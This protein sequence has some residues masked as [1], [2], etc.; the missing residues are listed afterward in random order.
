MSLFKLAST[1][2]PTGDQPEAI[3]ALTNS[4]AKSTKHQI[5]MGVTGSGKTFTM[6]NIIAAAE[7]PTLIIAPNKTLA[8]QLF[9]EMKDLFPENAVGF[10]IS[11]YDYYQPEAYIP[12]TDTYIAKDSS[13]NEDIDKM[14]HEATRFLFERRDTIIVASVSCI[15][16]LGSPETYAKQVVTV[17]KGDYIERNAFLRKLVDIQY[18]RNDISFERGC[19]RVRGDIVDILP[20]H[21]TDTGIRVEFFGD[22]IENIL[23]IDSLTGKAKESLTSLSIYPNSHYITDRNDIRNIVKDIL[24]DLGIRLRE[25]KAQDKLVEFQR[26]EQRTMHDV[27]LLEQLGFCPGI[28]NYSRYL[29]G[30]KPGEPP[31]TLLDYFPPGFI[32]IIDESHITVPQVRGMYRGDISRKQTLVDFG[33]RLPAAIDN[34]PLNFE[35]FLRKTG[36]LIYVSATPGKYEMESTD[37]K[38]FEQII[39]PTGIIDPQIE[40]RPAKN[41]VDDLLGELRKVIS[42][43]GRALVTTLTKKMSEDLTNYYQELGLKVRYLHSGIDSIER[44][45]LLRDLRKGNCDVLIGINLLREGLDLPE[46]T[47]VSVMDA[48]KQGFLRSASSLI[49]VVGRAARNKDGRVIF[50]GDE[51]TENMAHCL[52]ETERRRKKQLAYNEEHGIQPQSII[53]KMQPG[54]RELYGFTDPETSLTEAQVDELRKTNKFRSASE[55]DSLIKKQTKEMKTAAKNLDFERAAELRDNITTL[56]E[57]MLSFGDLGSPIEEAES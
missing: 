22:E 1:Y 19:F 14:R 32:T 5:L 31:P 42:Q 33:F 6:A 39:R 3:K 44:V 11:Y 17:A 52:N 47:L 53:K 10:F 27:E 30:K 35:E 8:A 37:G 16:G 41:Q 15:Y 4:I 51:I 55:L 12:G 9:T 56:K 13:I 7:H 46:V 20:A 34:R 23:L 21:Q 36:P 57:L 48:D 29:T 2:S 38:I 24:H 26:L 49:Q 54:L 43:G 28:E 40:V 18:T 45:E 50:Y 25:L